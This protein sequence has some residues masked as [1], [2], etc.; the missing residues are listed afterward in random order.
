[1]ADWARHFAVALRGATTRWKA[2]YI[3]RATWRAH[4]RALWGRVDDLGLRGQVEAI[5]GEGS[6][7]YRS[8]AYGR[9]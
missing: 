9:R 8:G 3:A 4:M 6:E 5:V 1:M 2:G 7:E